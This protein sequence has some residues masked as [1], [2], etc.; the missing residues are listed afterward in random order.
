MEFL[1][2]VEKI[3]EIR[4][5]I[6]FTLILFL[7]LLFVMMFNLY[8]AIILIELLVREIASVAADNHNHFLNPGKRR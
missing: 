1:N 3:R 4:H 6:V 7:I 2:N 8:E 5:I